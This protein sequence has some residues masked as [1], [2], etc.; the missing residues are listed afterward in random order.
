MTGRE[1]EALYD[2]AFPSPLSRQDLLDVHHADGQSVALLYGLDEVRINTSRPEISIP[3]VGWIEIED[4]ARRAD[5]SWVAIFDSNGQGN[6]QVV[7]GR[8]SPFTDAQP[9][10]LPKRHGKVMA[11]PFSVAKI[12]R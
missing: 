9:L 6:W 12:L 1:L 7:L 11:I 8:G 2:R 4:D 3:V 5:P 10:P